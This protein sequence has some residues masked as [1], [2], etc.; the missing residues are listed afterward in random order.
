MPSQRQNPP[1]LQN[2]LSLPVWSYQCVTHSHLIPQKVRVNASV[3]E[4]TFLCFE[5]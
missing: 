3:N 1:N 5:N 2:P 4:W